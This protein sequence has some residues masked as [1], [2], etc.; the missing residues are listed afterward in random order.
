[1]E[2]SGVEEVK[3]IQDKIRKEV[4]EVSSRDTRTRFQ[5]RFLELWLGFFLPI[6]P[7]EMSTPVAVGAIGTLGPF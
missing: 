4:K 3:E 5:R 6:M 7:L 2:E 1:M